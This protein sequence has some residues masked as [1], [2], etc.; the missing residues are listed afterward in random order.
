MNV[1]GRPGSLGSPSSHR[2]GLC[3]RLGTALRPAASKA[4]RGPALLERSDPWSKARGLLT[5][6]C[7]RSAWVGDGW[8]GPG[9][10]SCWGH[11]PEGSAEAKACTANPGERRHRGPSCSPAGTGG[12]AAEQAS[13]EG[14]EVGE[15]AAAASHQRDGWAVTRRPRGRASPA[16]KQRHQISLFLRFFQSGK[17]SRP[18]A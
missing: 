4:S 5:Q 11:R 6:C 7:S 1:W 3:P 13:E 17:R 14:E 10:R 2:Q 9:R 12:G 16:I 8:Q 15:A 18:R